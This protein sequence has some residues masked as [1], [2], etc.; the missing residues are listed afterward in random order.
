MDFAAL[1]AEAVSESAPTFGQ[2][3]HPVISPVLAP[4]ELL[5]PLRGFLE[6]HPF[7]R[8]VFGMTR[9]PDE[10]DDAVQDPMLAALAEASLD[11]SRRLSEVP[12]KADAGRLAP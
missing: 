7:E 1:H 6:S 2:A 9:F 10:Q 8:N 12:L 11:L 3:L 5:Q 4:P